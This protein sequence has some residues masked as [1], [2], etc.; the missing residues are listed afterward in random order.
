[1]SDKPLIQDF[2]WGIDNFDKKKEIKISNK[3][4]ADLKASAKPEETLKMQKES[5]MHLW[6][7]NPNEKKDIDRITYME[8][9]EIQ[10]EIQLENW[11]ITEEEYKIALYNL[12]EKEVSIE[13]KKSVIQWNIYIPT[14]DSLESNG[15][16]TANDTAKLVEYIYNNTN[17]FT[18]NNKTIDISKIEWLENVKIINEYFQKVDNADNMDNENVNLQNFQNDFPD[19]FNESNKYEWLEEAIFSIIWRNYIKIEWWI[20]SENKSKE[21]IILSA[22]NTAANKINSLPNALSSNA[23]DSQTLI[24]AMKNIQSWNIEK[25]LDWFTSLYTLVFSNIWKKWSAMEKWKKM[26]WKTLKNRLDNIAKNIEMI[27][28]QIELWNNTKEKQENLEKQLDNLNKEQ[29]EIQQWD[30]FT[31]TEVD[32]Q[33][34][35]NDSISETK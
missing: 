13:D 4:I 8:A 32:V 28:H 12:T 19:Y 5:Q 34:E 17:S 26:L 30:I 20:N 35:W 16:I 22:I 29:E 27:E 14:I 6:R 7:L 18:D 33:K 23:R 2:S 15:L 24:N 9:L 31:A 1:M 21:I 11:E 10:L 25:A 3:E